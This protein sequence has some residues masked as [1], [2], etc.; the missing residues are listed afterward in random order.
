MPLSVSMQRDRSFNKFAHL[1]I[2]NLAVVDHQVAADDRLRRP[3]FGH[4]TLER[5]VILRRL[6]E[7]GC[8]RLLFFHIHDRDSLSASSECGR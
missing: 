3:A 6:A 2:R 7:L 8:D 4:E 1:L 5:R